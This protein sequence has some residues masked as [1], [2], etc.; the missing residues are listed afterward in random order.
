MHEHFHMVQY[1]VEHLNVRLYTVYCTFQ[2][3]SELVYGK[4]HF[5]VLSIDVAFL[6]LDWASQV[7]NLNS[8][9]AILTYFP[10]LNNALL[11]CCSE[12]LLSLSLGSSDL[13]ALHFNWTL[14][15]V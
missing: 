3:P 9:R 6:A 14:H 5:L 12:L 15:N 7:L 13:T 10:F 4:V 1:R 11:I 2:K 8:L